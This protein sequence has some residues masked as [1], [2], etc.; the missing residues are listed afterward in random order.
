MADGEPRLSRAQREMRD[1]GNPGRP[2][3]GSLHG[4]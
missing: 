4:E 2:K 3:G 1:L